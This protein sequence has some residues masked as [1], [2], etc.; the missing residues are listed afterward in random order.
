MHGCKHGELVSLYLRTW[1]FCSIFA[2]HQYARFAANVNILLVGGILW[3]NA[4]P[5]QN[6][7]VWV[8][9]YFCCVKEMWARPVLSIPA[10]PHSNNFLSSDFYTKSLLIGSLVTFSGPRFGRGIQTLFSNFCGRWTTVPLF[11]YLDSQNSRFSQEGNIR[12]WSSSTGKN[13]IN[14]AHQSGACEISS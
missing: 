2:I 10:I 13:A 4:A 5:T 3:Q 6:L 7:G 14:I 1:N 11:A 9:F 8:Q 12:M